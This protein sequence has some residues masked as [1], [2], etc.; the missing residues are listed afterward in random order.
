MRLPKVSCICPTFARTHLLEE[1]VESFLRQDYEGEL[2]LI[3]LND[4]VEQI[5]KFTSD[6]RVRIFNAYRRYETL[7]EKRHSAYNLASGDLFLTWGDDDIHLPH[8]VSRMV[9]FLGDEGMAYEG[10][11]FV[12]HADG[13]F[14]ERK[15]TAG[16]HI[17]KAEVY[18]KL[19]GIPSL[20]IGEDVAF[21]NTAAKTLGEIRV[22][23]ESPAFLYRWHGTNRTHVSGTGQDDPY[24]VM[25]ARAN[26]LVASGE[27]PFGEIK[28]RPRW[29]ENY[30]EKVKEAIVR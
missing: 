24:A 6:P 19:G 8:R 16:A 15:S 2:E 3:V 26:Q 17:I 23:K 7:G 13:I 1:A 12:S 9:N 4:F 28:L 5:I 29:R 25:L 14:L 18:H 20:S 30:C 11:F 27:E 10:W 21:N 22:C